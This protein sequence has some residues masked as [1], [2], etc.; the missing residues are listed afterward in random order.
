M[1]KSG[2]DRTRTCKSFQVL[3]YYLL[4]NPNNQIIRGRYIANPNRCRACNGPILPK[5]G[6]RL[7]NVRQKIFCDSSCAASF[8]NHLFPKKKSV[9]KVCVKCFQAFSPPNHRIKTCR[10]C[11]PV[12]STRRNL[13]ELTKQEAGR[14]VIGRHAARVMLNRSKK[15]IACGYST[16]VDVAHLKPVA[17]FSPQ[18][19]LT[20]INAPENLVYLCPNHH[21]EFDR[22]YLKL[23]GG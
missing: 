3:W 20:E 8:N 15:C 4:V 18:A 5:P 11:R 22:G 19:K 9:R 1:K 10:D 13:G 21:R 14:V 16:F 2:G 23:N 12:R 7:F 6:Q 17:A